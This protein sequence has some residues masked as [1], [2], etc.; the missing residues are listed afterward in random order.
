[1]RRSA[2]RVAFISLAFVS[3][4]A[5]RPPVLV[6][7]P[8]A[9]PVEP[10]PAPQPPP[11][12]P[13]VTAL[14]AAEAAF[15][16]GRD[17]SSAGHLHDARLAFDKA[18]DILLTVPGGAESDPRLS[19]GLQALVD[20][21]SALELAALSRGDGFTETDSEPAPIDA[22]L[23]LAETTTTLVEPPAP[24]VATTV[25]A[26]LAATAHDIPIPMND[27]VLKYVELFQGRLRGFLEEG[28]ARGAAYM[29][30]IQTV[31]REQALPLDLAYVPLVESAF[32]A[33]AL[34]RAS[35][36]GVWQF[37]RETGKENGLT[38][39]WYIDERANPEKATRAA[40]KYLK[41]LYDT[42][43]DWHLALASYNG[44]P[45]RVQRAVKRTGQKDFWRLS[46]TSRY[47][48]RE[49]REYVPMLLAAMIIA[50]NPTQYGFDVPEPAPATAETVA[51]SGP[52]DLRR[53]AEWAGVTA[54]AIRELN[55]ELRRWTTPVRDDSYTLRVPVGTGPAVAQAH[56]ATDPDEAAAL[57]WHEVRKGESL[58]LLA[59][60]LGVSRADLA[61]AN[62]LS[63]TARLTPGQRLVIPRAPSAAMLARR[64][65]PPASGKTAAR[66]AASDDEAVPTTVV[67][68]V[69]KGDT[70]YSI[71]RKHGVTIERLRAWNQ[72]KGSALSIGDRLRIHTSRPVDT[73]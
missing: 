58:P 46:S 63:R 24:D 72:L 26:D 69:R 27:R 2:V 9:A 22:L 65:D 1:M 44:G 36:R 73:Q 50:R 4:C 17:A 47:L 41:A 38:H 11:P 6:T 39:D 40:A 64:T 37:M 29:P 57:Q 32:K 30:M 71:A 16:A 34:S 19:A 48:P 60:R 13:V 59:R 42:F 43:D 56:G 18:V 7:A 45:G 66:S 52:V 28:L 5:S 70:L 61:D 62:Y 15:A 8:V 20:R 54:D 67:Y 23:S 35:A 68:R 14:A 21:I 33:T 53:V 12:D 25:R 51:L 31:F 49:T 3:A 10:A 55:P